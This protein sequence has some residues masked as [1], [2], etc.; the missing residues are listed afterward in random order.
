MW[1]IYATFSAFSNIFTHL[2]GGRILLI[3]TI[4]EK[5]MEKETLEGDS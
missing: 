2:K 1:L 3:G 5:E 4:E